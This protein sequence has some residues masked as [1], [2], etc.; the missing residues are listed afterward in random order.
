MSQLISSCAESLPVL[1]WL[2]S[3]PRWKKLCIRRVHFIRRSPGAPSPMPERRVRDEETG[4]T[5][6]RRVLERINDPVRQVFTEKFRLQELDQRGD[7]IDSE[8]SEWTLRWAPRQEMRY[9]FELTGF[10]VVA[11]YSDFLRSPP[12]YGKEQLWVVRKP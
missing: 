6:V 3:K 9:L 2:K 10:E 4:R 8:E 12:A 11:E 1:V 5:A 7:P